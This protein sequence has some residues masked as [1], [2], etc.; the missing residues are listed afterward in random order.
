MKKSSR[1]ET[2]ISA[3]SS[4]PKVSKEDDACDHMELCLLTA[5]GL[6]THAEKSTFR[7]C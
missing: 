2:E 6:G 5:N 7:Y 3:P 1:D 4:I